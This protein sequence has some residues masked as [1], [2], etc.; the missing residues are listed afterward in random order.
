MDIRRFF[1]PQTTRTG[2]AQS[3][4]TSKCIGTAAGIGS[5]KS[6]SQTKLK[7]GVTDSNDET[8]EHSTKEKK[9]KMKG[10]RCYIISDSESDAEEPPPTKRELK[11]S[12]KQQELLIKTPVYSISESESDTEK[13][14]PTK[15]A[16]KQSSKNTDDLWTN[17]P[18]CSISS[19]DGCH[20]AESKL[21]HNID[22]WQR[23][24]GTKS[25]Q[26]ASTS[27]KSKDVSKR[28]L[29]L[30]KLVPISASDYFG[31]GN[32][33]QSSRP[34]M[35]S[36]CKVESEKKQD[37]NSQNTVSKVA[38]EQV[39]ME[40]ELHGDEEFARTLAMLDEQEDM[41]DRKKAARSLAEATAQAKHCL[42]HGAIDNLCF[43]DERIVDSDSE[44]NIEEA[45]E[46]FLWQLKSGVTD[47][48]DETKEHST[49]EKK[50]KMKGKR[51][52]IISDSES[53]AEEPPPTKRELKRSKKQQ[54]L[55]IK[56]PV[57][58]I[59]ESESDTEKSPPTKHAVKQSSKN[60]DD[61]W[62]N[63]PACSISSPDD[64]HVA[65]S[66]LGHNIDDWQRRCGTKSSQ[67]ASTSTKSKDVSKR[68]LS[69]QKLVPI[70]ASDYFGSGNIHQS[71][72]PLMA[73]K[74]KVESEKKQDVNSQ[75]TV[76][77]VAREQVEM[78]LELHGD[79]EFARTL[80][81]LDE[82]EDMPD[83]K[84]ARVEKKNE[85]PVGQPK[86]HL[87]Y[88]ESSKTP[89]SNDHLPLAGENAMQTAAFG[90]PHAERIPTHDSVNRDVELG[91]PEKKG[92]Q[93]DS[94]NVKLGKSPEDVEKKRLSQLS[95]RNFLNR[96]G[97]RALGSKEIPKGG[98]N[99]LEGLTFVITGVLESMERDEAKSL[100]ERYGGKVTGNVSKRTDFV[101][102][103]RDAGQSKLQKAESCRTRMLD[104]DGLLEL[105]RTRPA[106]HSKYEKIA[107]LELSKAAAAL[108]TT[109]LQKPEPG[110]LKKGNKSGSDEAQFCASVSSA[111][112]YTSK[113]D[114]GNIKSELNVS[115]ET[116][117]RT[118]KSV[119]VHTQGMSASG[120]SRDHGHSSQASL[121]WVDRYRPC[122]L[123]QV[124][125]QQGEQ[126]PA[127]KLL[128][129]LRDWYK[130]RASGGFKAVPAGRFG[131]FGK[132]DG[133]S[134]RAAL[135][136]GPPG[137][138]K[139]TTAVLACQELGY[140]YVELNA[141]DSRSKNSLKNDVATSLL[142]TNIE[143]FYHGRSCVV[144]SQHVLI[145]DEVD[146]MAG[147]EDRGGIQELVGLIKQTKVPIICMCNDRNHQKIRSLSNY[148]F[149]LRFQRPRMEQI[150]GAMMS[151]TFKENIRVPPPALQEI[152]LAANHDIRQI[153]HNLSMWSAAN[154]T[155]NYDEVKVDANKA[156]KDIKLGP[157]DVARKVFVA[158]EETRKMSLNDKSDL[159]FND[160][161][162][163][164]LFVYE[165]YLH[166]RPHA[167]GGNMK[168]HLT[169]LSKAAESI[170]NGDL[171]DRL[172][173]SR[174]LWK[175]LPTQ[176][177]FSSVIP[178]E[179]MRG[180]MA[181]FPS[182][183][184]WL[185]RRSAAGRQERLLQEL[186]MHTCLGTRSNSRAIVLDYA[187]YLRHA[188]AAPLVTR[189]A[190]GVRDT[191]NIMASYHLT[192]EDVDNLM[193]LTTFPGRPDPMAQL[194]SKV[195]AALTRAYNKE[196]HLAPYA[197]SVVAKKSRKGSGPIDGEEL[198]GEERMSGDDTEDECGVETDGMVK[199]KKKTK[200]TKDAE[201]ETKARSSRERKNEKTKS[202]HRK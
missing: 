83:R 122:S 40:L 197:L 187:G 134:F 26:P 182:F 100:V 159:F 8:K 129:W 168:Q 131:K 20:V 55:L 114:C 153:L 99:C 77:K 140:K 78:E 5:N 189:G 61:L 138:G 133:A 117:S 170:A 15:H 164:P 28:M 14:P 137:V 136:S 181:Q 132:D 201:A 151:V 152:I 196:P 119:R 64:C 161:S 109:E 24:C 98:E 92:T 123:K 71:S 65:E 62:T 124:I 176:A 44:G 43:W 52:Y 21:G 27:T 47:S 93:K 39:E 59:S 155:L 185:G 147:N 97:P 108:R 191:L 120:K 145:M 74:C 183:P 172:I 54:E 86:K 96:E 184:S 166:V 73:S 116:A 31:S 130:N 112:A 193:E 113:S 42:A 173:R 58:S 111:A 29:S 7:S 48:N 67:P 53:D 13:S 163:A 57:Y 128:R 102:V 198:V 16:V 82:Q 175:L 179:L 22:D 60:T 32:I 160:Y 126:S 9:T 46:D 141:S 63:T 125:G 162:L 103:G 142:N 3:L 139:T 167:A 87:H 38:R 85:V 194:E 70:S 121:L 76:S 72:R 200:A 107:Q 115:A 143:D 1:A 50:T 6:S 106:Q 177:F 180:Y 35:A 2:S 25:S 79:E 10:K 33:H 11:R 49:K 186:T 150:K 104:E 178:G 127:N 105:I 135:L 174:Q 41:P 169:L 149:D 36:K 202:R 69:L 156:K 195:K 154:K 188:V 158:D 18:A 75:N 190:D 101:V 51:C 144:S 165:N 17:T 34:L 88:R 91:S 199:Q 146:G 90:K 68:M 192:K 45:F 110:L 66:K 23:R 94:P 81:M 37:V 12:K 171:V 4:D 157:F 95:Y 19:P 30:Q 56:T 84:K 148:C 118:G 89:T 80:A